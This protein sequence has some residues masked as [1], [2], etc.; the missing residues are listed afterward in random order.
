A[1]F[2]DVGTTAGTVAAGDDSRLSDARTPTAH[3]HAIEEVTGLAD[4]LAEAGGGDAWD[5]QLRDDFTSTSRTMA[6]GSFA[7]STSLVASESGAS[8]IARLST[9]TTQGTGR[10]E[11]D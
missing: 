4:A 7:G 8:G 6:L 10:A 5:V 2:L 9:G 3:G 11:L 1:A